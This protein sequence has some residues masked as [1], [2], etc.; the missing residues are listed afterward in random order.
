[1]FPILTF[2]KLESVIMKVKIYVYRVLMWT[3][4]MV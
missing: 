4:F 2:E 1:M 3:E